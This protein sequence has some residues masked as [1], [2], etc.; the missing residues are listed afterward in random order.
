MLKIVKKYY[1]NNDNLRWC[2]TVKGDGTYYGIF[3]SFYIR[4]YFHG[5]M[6]LRTGG[7]GVVIEFAY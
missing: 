7:N 2:Y 3:K 5:I 1:D 4:D 6:F